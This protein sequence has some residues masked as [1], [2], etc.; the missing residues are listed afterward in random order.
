N[1]SSI[2]RSFYIYNGFMTFVIWYY[3]AK[4][5]TNR[6]FYVVRFLFIQGEYIVFKYLI[7][8]RRLLEMLRRE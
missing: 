3:K 4:R 8:I 1:G 5:F 6:K 7:Y 2:K